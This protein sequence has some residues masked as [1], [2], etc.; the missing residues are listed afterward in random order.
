[1]KEMSIGEFARRSRLSPKALR[2]YDSLGLLVPAR[3]DELSGYRYYESL[4]L[5]PARLIANLRQVGVPLAE[6]KELLALDPAEMAERVTTFWHETETRHAG[7]RKLVAALVDRLT[8]RNTVTVVYE[9][10]IREMPQRSLLCLKR[11]VDEAGVW[12]FGKEFIGIIRDQR[13]PRLPGREGAMFLIFW[14]QVSG[15]SDG[16]VECCKPVPDADAEAL[17]AQFPEL[18]LRVEPAHREA[19]VDFGAGLVGPEQWPLAEE[20]LGAWAIG[21]G[22]DPRQL[23][24]VSEDL[25]V[26][27]TYLF[28]SPPV[29]KDSVTKCDFAVPFG[30][31][32]PDGA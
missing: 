26:R 5:E 6:V 20:A 9:V 28:P 31:A 32:G 14:G 1:V 25:G 21:Q 19:Y 17:A 16:P 8:G 7:K 22:M 24:P 2:L 15:D 3:V 18:T 10:A 27:M 13:L 23:T 30:F 11:N 29:T 4:Q 12:A